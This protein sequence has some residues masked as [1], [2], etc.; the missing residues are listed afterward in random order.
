MTKPEPQ[1][2]ITASM[3]QHW[4]QQIATILDQTTRESGQYLDA[5]GDALDE[6]AVSE[7]LGSFLAA[8]TAADTAFGAAYRAAG[9][10]ATTAP[11]PTTATARQAIAGQ[12]RY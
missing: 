7:I 3:A 12:P 11:Q 8:R 10:E 4:F 1:P 9:A 6:E 2:A 5:L